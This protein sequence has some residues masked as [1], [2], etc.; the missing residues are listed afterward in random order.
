MVVCMGCVIV[1][2]SDVEL[3]KMLS[4]YEMFAKMAYDRGRGSRV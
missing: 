4:C 1:E 2:M 3:G